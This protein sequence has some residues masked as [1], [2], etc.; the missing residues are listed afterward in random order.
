MTSEQLQ[1]YLPYEKWKIM[2]NDIKTTRRKKRKEK[3][4]K[5][6]KI[7]QSDEFADPVLDKA[8]EQS[9]SFEIMN[10]GTNIPNSSLSIRVSH[11]TEP[12]ELSPP[13]AHHDARM[14]VESG[15]Q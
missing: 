11:P 8:L 12:N 5:N 3:L 1:Q 10:T 13:N 6:E 14:D 2:I 9:T 15:R 7:E 4:G